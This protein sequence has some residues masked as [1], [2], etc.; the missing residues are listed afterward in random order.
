MKKHSIKAGGHI[1]KLGF[2]QE[3]KTLVN[4]NWEFKDW[5]SMFAYLQRA[6]KQHAAFEESATKCMFKL[7]CRQKFYLWELRWLSISV[8]NNNNNEIKPRDWS[9]IEFPNFMRIEN[10]LRL[11]IFVNLP[12]GRNSWT[13]PTYLGHYWW[14]SKLPQNRNFYPYLC[15]PT[16]RPRLNVGPFFLIGIVLVHTI[17]FVQKQTDCL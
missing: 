10:I 9:I 13:F 16:S 17:F 12:T 6:T 4:F 3:S 15:L 2:H 7:E 8:S 14:Y 1:A 5:D 11:F